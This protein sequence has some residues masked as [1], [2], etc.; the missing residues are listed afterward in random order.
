[1]SSRSIVSIPKTA[2][3]CGNAEQ[4]RRK[5]IA[6]CG[7][8]PPPFLSA[9]SGSK[10]FFGLLALA[11]CLA[12]CPEVFS[13]EKEEIPSPPPFAK[14]ANVSAY[15]GHPQE[16]SLQVG[17]RIVE[18][19]VFLIRKAPQLGTLGEI[20]RTGRNT[21]VVLYTPNPDGGPGVDSFSF[22]AKSIDSPVSAPAT[23]NIQLLEEPPRVEFPEALE[24]GTVLVGDTVEKSV[25]IRNTGGG[26]AFWQINPPPPWSVKNSGIYRVPG[27]RESLLHLSFTP[28]DERDF[29]ARIQMTSDPKSTLLITGSGIIPISWSREGIVFS[30][31]KRASNT[32][33]IVFTNKTN[34][35]LKAAISWPLFL[36]GPAEVLL[37]A[38]AQM[39]LPLT[40][41]A[42]LDFQFA[43]E[44]DVRCGNYVGHIPTRIFPAPAK[45]AVSPEK[46]LQLG[47][48]RKDTP[49]KGR[50]LVKN[51]G[52]TDA[53]LSID[54]PSQLQ[55][56]PDARNL[57]LQPNQEQ[58]FDVQLN[59]FQSDSFQGKI[60][61]TSPGI[62]T[63]E[64]PIAA[65]APKVSKPSLPVE[66]F[67]RIPAPAPDSPS[68]PVPGKG[69]AVEKATLVSSLPHEIVIEW[70]IPAPAPAR[71][72]IERRLVST[73][74]DGGVLIK[75]KAW[76]GVGITIVE[77]SATA[78]FER[79]PANTFWTIRIV[80][81]DKDGK[82]GNPSPAFQIA[83]QPI[84]QWIIPV[85]FWIL[86][87]V[88]IASALFFA[89]R[90]HQR[91]LHAKANERIAR[92]SNE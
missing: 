58:A 1:M 48:L 70:K 4:Q 33:G 14:T 57:I 26:I 11:I 60:R 76:Q 88:G 44:V 92:L 51:V 50:F 56:T 89:F 13:K 64:L 91:R 65:T 71:F 72:L 31:E 41:A 21:A 2:F 78:R 80:P 52:G 40:L 43:G 55:I 86:L 29:Q 19:L 18:P 46:A 66:S 28:T 35:D 9:L 77:G 5:R 75:W 68:V 25:P 63:V 39:T 73:G 15:L 90:Q 37:P 61:I 8:F 16:I 47:E 67:L 83:T 42:P 85:W 53:P 84:R 22:A 74:P 17:G 30:P 32:T 38:R 12:F 24:F 34:S 36:K 7:I 59:P 27:G 81:L 54:A 45:L 82:P 6:C 10:A 49:L 87:L 23:V 3:A 69:P 62:E 79:L 20:R